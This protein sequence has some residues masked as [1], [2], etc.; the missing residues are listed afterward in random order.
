MVIHYLAYNS[1]YLVD[2]YCDG[3][4]DTC[5]IDCGLNI[6]NRGCMNTS[7]YCSNDDDAETEA[8]C[9]VV[10]DADNVDETCPRAALGSYTI[11]S[12]LPSQFTGGAKDS[13]VVTPTMTQFTNIQLPTTYS[14]HSIGNDRENNNGFDIGLNAGTIIGACGVLSICLCAIVVFYCFRMRQNQEGKSR[15]NNY[16]RK[17]KKKQRDNANRAGGTDTHAQMQKEP[18]TNNRHGEFDNGKAH[19]HVHTHDTDMDVNNNYKEYHQYDSPQAELELEIENEHENENESESENGNTGLL[20]ADIKLPTIVQQISN[21]SSDG[22]TPGGDSNVNYNNGNNNRYEGRSNLKQPGLPQV[23]PAPVNPKKNKIKRMIKRT[24]GF[25][26]EKSGRK[27][28]N[29]KETFT[30][31]KDTDQSSSDLYGSGNGS[32]GVTNTPYATTDFGDAVENNNEKNKNKN[33]NTKKNKNNRKS[34]VKKKGF[35]VKIAIFEKGN[36]KNKQN[37]PSGAIGSQSPTVDNGNNN[38]KNN[39]Y[40]YGDYIATAGKS[41]GKGKPKAKV[42]GGGS[43]AQASKNTK[44][45]QATAGL[46]NIALAMAVKESN[47]RAKKTGNNMTPSGN[48]NNYNHNNTQRGAPKWPPNKAGTAGGPSVQ[49]GTRRPVNP[50]GIK[51]TQG[52]EFLNRYDNNLVDV[53]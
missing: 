40:K 16:T 24:R 15:Y 48:N 29:R 37:N 49:S 25:S 50:V 33:K 1:G 17:K 5:Y 53:Q 19:F 28:T 38:S 14:N 41:K 10:C 9:F 13:A 36:T 3:Y 30:S 7:I 27:A 47:S 42:T 8:K 35:G 34:K 18:Q 2:I 32:E 21:Q 12:Q 52:G 31:T 46:E 44:G 20:I 6:N 22:M 45:A 26:G 4:N 51:A 39:N 23:P 11:I 43:K